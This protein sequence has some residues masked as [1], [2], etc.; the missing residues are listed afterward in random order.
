MVKVLEH[1]NKLRGYPDGSNVLRAGVHGIIVVVEVAMLI[2][3]GRTIRDAFSM[4]G[5]ARQ[6][7]EDAAAELGRTGGQRQQ[8]LAAT[9]ERADPI[10]K[11]VESFKA[12]MT[13]S[14]NALN[15]AA[16]EFE[17]SAD[18]L[19]DAAGHAKDRVEAASSAFAETTARVTSVS[20]ARK[21]TSVRL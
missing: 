9:N 14:I 11:L 6:R 17:R 13:D 18:T 16:H 2:F 15:T 19:G 7:A 12:E 10:D 8:D 5:K 4:A 3:I 20:E 21:Q 1:N